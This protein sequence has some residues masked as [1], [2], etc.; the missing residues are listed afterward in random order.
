MEYVP[1][2]LTSGA[3]PLAA[4]D[5][6]AVDT[7]TT[8][9][10]V[11]RARVVQ[12]AAVAIKLGK[13]ACDEAYQT[14]VD[15]GEPIPAAST[16]IHGI[17][18]DAVR[19]APGFASMLSAFQQFRAGRLLIGHSIGFDLAVIEHE[20]RRARVTWSKPRSLCLRLLGS[21][22]NP[23]LPEG[24][25]DALASWLGVSIAGRHTAPGDAAAA[26]EI[27]S[28]LLPHLAGKGITTLAGAEV[29]CLRRT[30]LLESG[31][32]AGWSEPVSRP[33]P[34][35]AGALDPY[36]YSHRVQELM[37]HP[38]A[39]VAET[40]TARQAVDLMVER[41]I[42]SI[43]VSTNGE[44]GGPL[45]DYGIVTE[46]DIM[47]LVS[48]HGAE[49]L[50]KQVA[51]FSSRPLASIAGGAFVYR[52]ISRMN[53]LKLR[54][55]AVRDE[56]ERL[57]GIISARDLLRLRADA[58]IS[59]DDQIGAATSAT[60]MAQAW[61]NL[62]AVARALLAEKLDSYLVAGIVSEEI[63]VMSRRAAELA[64]KS[65]IEDGHGEPPCSY[66]LMVLGSGGRGESLLAPDQDNAIVYAEGKP[67]GAADRWFAELGARIADALDVAGIPYCKGGVMARNE[68]WR[69]SVATWKARI[70]HWVGRARG[71]DL[72]NVDIF[73]DERP[74]HGNL[75]LGS[76]LFDYAFSSAS[77]NTAFAKMMGETLFARPS[78][79]GLFGALQT[80]QGRIDLKLHGLFP[81]VTAARTMAIRRN[82][83]RR[84]TRDRLEGL[85]KLGLGNSEEIAGLIA[86]HRLFM[87][88]MLDQQAHDLET[89]NAVSNWVD[90]GAL[91]RSRQSELKSALRAVQA[92]PELVRSTMFG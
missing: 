13:A 56:H 87:A 89:G 90:V 36:A 71:E 70:D 54:H 25:L 57:A 64:E 27:Y 9:L 21:I 28:A 40:T 55:L 49:A 61:A 80:E 39:V 7:E 50:Q 85:A 5:A 62:P 63:R 52:A 26:A 16:A 76:E 74:T 24:S 91:D 59:L 42:S 43:F 14:L 34:S 6:V 8:G 79:F 48:Q 83:A 41:R 33:Q 29:S 38:A 47:R 51:D 1:E 46:R 82:I 15:P 18:D 67:D 53:R 11:T 92:A 22:V 4:L 3:T 60:E 72:L 10:D 30:E 66:A 45:S 20:A 69:G 35:Q 31:Y 58:A 88:L 75:A 84:S 81:V 86:A 78:P 19:G 68:P 32:R 23:N 2:R 77:G 12:L 17:T 44:P 37:S 65:M 73:F